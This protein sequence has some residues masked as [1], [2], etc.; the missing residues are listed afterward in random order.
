MTTLLELLSTTARSILPSRLKSPATMAVGLAAFRLP[1]GWKVPLPM[2]N[3]TETL[4]DAKFAT[5]RS[6]LPSPL[7]SPTAMARGLEPAL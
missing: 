4:S 3:S 6:S 1:K 5:A 7:K 2:P